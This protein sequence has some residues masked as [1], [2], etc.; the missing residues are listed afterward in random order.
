MNKRIEQELNE[1]I[2]QTLDNSI[3][4]ID[5]ATLAK[6]HQVRARAIDRIGLQNNNGF[7]FIA[8]GLAAACVMLF[9]VMIL[10]QSPDNSQ[11]LPAN[12]IELI[13]SS[14]DL[15]LFEDL[16]FYEWL[17]QDALFG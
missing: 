9:A 6:V 8:G 11:G 10:L 7:G 2:K 17:E 16:E 15:E 3:D 13:S 5:T 1:N 12:D 4:E 14:D